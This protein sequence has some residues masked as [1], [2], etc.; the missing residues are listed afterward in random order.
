MKVPRIVHVK[1]LEE[2]KLLVEFDD[3]TKKEYNVKRLLDKY[4][5][6]EKLKNKE[7]FNLVHV[8]CGGFGIAWT[9]EIDLSRYEI[10]HNGVPAQ[11]QLVPGT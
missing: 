2:L 6:F 10:W 8:D 1:P 11:K 4:E 7:V 9:D 3:N 5:V